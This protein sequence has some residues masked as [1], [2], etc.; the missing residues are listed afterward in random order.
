MR[1]YHGTLKK[2][3][4]PILLGGLRAGFGAGAEKPGVFLSSSYED[5]MHWAKK[6]QKKAEKRGEI[7]AEPIVLVVD[8][9]EE[10]LENVIKRTNN[11]AKMHFEPL[12][13]DK[14]YLGSIPAKYIS[15]MSD[16]MNIR[17]SIKTIIKQAILSE[18]SKATPEFMSGEKYLDKIT[19]F[20]TYGILRAPQTEQ[21]KAYND[22]F[23]SFLVRQY[24]KIFQTGGYYTKNY[25]ET[26]KLADLTVDDFIKQPY[27]GDVIHALAHEATLPDVH[28][29]F[30][31]LGRDLDRPEAYDNIF[32]IV[33]YWLQSGAGQANRL[34]TG[35]GSMVV[36]SL[37][38]R[39]PKG[40]KPIDQ[41]VADFFQ[42]YGSQFDAGIITNYFPDMEKHIGGTE[43]SLMPADGQRGFI[44]AIK[45]TVGKL[46]KS[47]TTKTNSEALFVDVL[48][49]F[50]KTMI[51]SKARLDFMPEDTAT[52]LMSW[53]N[54]I[55]LK[56]KALAKKYGFESI[57]SLQ[58]KFK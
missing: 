38:N 39:L 42:R 17:E 8:L 43:P 52:K 19:P 37:T 9:P 5:A 3:V 13:N 12:P 46:K 48:S 10:E 25:L 16:N 57:E 29:R 27:A 49:R 35:G 6:T 26:G 41:L 4:T 20:G 23:V 33:V 11:F 14:Q 32:E 47:G 51:G 36:R 56:S 30:R 18:I 24:D 22:E 1:F 2:N 50:A 44:S 15:V 7:D 34:T 58:K 21:E 28:K 54:A 40:E 45:N 53:Y 55:S 31:T